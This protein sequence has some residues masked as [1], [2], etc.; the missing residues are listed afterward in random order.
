MGGAAVEGD[1]RL[2]LADLTLQSSH[3]LSRY[4]WRVRRD[5]MHAKPLCGQPVEEVAG[6]RR[7]AVCNLQGVDVGPRVLQR[8]LRDVDCEH[9][10]PRSVAPYGAGYGAAA[11]AHVD[12]P[13][14]L[15]PGIVESL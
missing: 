3:D 13:G 14:R 8:I 5:H 1:G 6:Y 7:H 9:P 15:D 4:V 2:M 11:S 12:G 10:A